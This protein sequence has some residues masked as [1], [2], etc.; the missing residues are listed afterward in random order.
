MMGRAQEETIKTSLSRAFIP[1]W[2]LDAGAIGAGT[3][4]DQPPTNSCS[5][6]GTLVPLRKSFAN[7]L[8]HP[9]PLYLRGELSKAHAKV[10]C[11]DHAF[12]SPIEGEGAYHWSGLV[13]GVAPKR[14]DATRFS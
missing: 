10:L 7:V 8:R 2:S 13:R 6:I 3:L 12:D 11:R 5:P 14:I 9:K 4:S 1:P